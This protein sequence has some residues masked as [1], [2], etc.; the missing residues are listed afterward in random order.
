MLIRLAKKLSDGKLYF[1]FLL[2]KA[3]TQLE[4]ADDTLY[5]ITLREVANINE[6]FDL[7]IS[8]KMIKHIFGKRPNNKQVNSTDQLNTL[9]TFKT[10]KAEFYLLL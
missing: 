6:I 7:N 10:N 1:I 3:L 2:G 5:L 4:S 8:L 9:I